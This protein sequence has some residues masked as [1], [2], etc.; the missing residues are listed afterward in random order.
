LS[1]SDLKPRGRL[2]VISAPSGAGKTTLKDLLLEKVDGI[3][4]SI[5]ATT[6]PRRKNE[7][8]GVHYFFYTKNEF[9]NLIDRGAF[10]EYNE[11]HGNLYGTP[12]SLVQNEL[13]LGRSLV[14]DLDVHGK[15]NFDKVFPETTGILIEPPSIDILRQRLEDRKSDSNKSI[16]LRLKNAVEELEFARNEGNYK[17]TVINN[18]VQEALTELVSIVEREMDS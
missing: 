1:S 17:Y 9:Q 10:I 16:E 13:S 8:N 6:R 3:T 2:F 11:V 7:K 4:Y 18:S 12:K 5:S 14:F 15:V